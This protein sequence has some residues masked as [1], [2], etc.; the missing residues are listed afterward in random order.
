MHFSWRWRVALRAWD[1]GRGLLV[2]PR[3]REAQ[4]ARVEGHVGSSARTGEG[5]RPIP[6]LIPETPLKTMARD[7]TN[8]FF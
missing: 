2:T 6:Q 3:Q 5:S 1:Q 4:H 7:I 8:L